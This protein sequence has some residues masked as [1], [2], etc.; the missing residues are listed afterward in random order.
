ML[1]LSCFGDGVCLCV[2]F[3]ASPEIKPLFGAG[4]DGRTERV[5]LCAPGELRSVPCPALLLLLLSQPLLPVMEL[6]CYL[7][8]V[9]SSAERHQLEQKASKCLLY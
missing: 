4:Q 6:L 2:T 7:R 3:P 9:C 8:F 5:L 1:F